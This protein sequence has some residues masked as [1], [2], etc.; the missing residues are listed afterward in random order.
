MDVPYTRKKK[1]FELSNSISAPSYSYMSA[2]PTGE[3]VT[4]ILCNFTHFS[5]SMS[6]ITRNKA[7][8]LNTISIIQSF[9][10][11]RYFSVLTFT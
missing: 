11:D 9:I 2:S 4:D 10:V 3:M 6:Y 5:N 7:H 1:E 8:Y